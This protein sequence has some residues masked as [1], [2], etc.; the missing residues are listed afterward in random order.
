VINPPP[1]RFQ[2]SARDLPNAIAVL[3]CDYPGAFIAAY[4]VDYIDQDKMS[5]WWARKRTEEL[6]SETA[7]EWLR[8]WGTKEQ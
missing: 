4:E 2:Y 7:E 5:D 6:S 1:E 3:K 8:R